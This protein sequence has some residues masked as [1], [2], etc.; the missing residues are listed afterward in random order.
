[1]YQGIDKKNILGSHERLAIE[2]RYSILSILSTRV[3]ELSMSH[4]IGGQIA[5]ELSN[6]IN[7][8]PDEGLLSLVLFGS[9]LSDEPVMTRQSTIR[10]KPLKNSDTSSDRA[11]GGNPI[12]TTVKR[13]RSIRNGN[14]NAHCQDKVVWPWWYKFKRE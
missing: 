9:F 13:G 5:L 12:E 4:H 3:S 8:K 7:P 14:G 2:V 10:P 11:S 1:M 6:S